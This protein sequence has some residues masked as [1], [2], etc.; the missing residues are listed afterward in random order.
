LAPS[1]QIAVV[2]P[3]KSPLFEDIY[4]LTNKL[5]MLRQRIKDESLSRDIGDL[6]KLAGMYCQNDIDH[7]DARKDLTERFERITDRL[8]KAIRD[9]A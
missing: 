2:V 8:G 3:E 7:R 4:Q 6:S 5:W 1:G 9:L